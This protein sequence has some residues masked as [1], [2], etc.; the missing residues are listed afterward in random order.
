MFT[1]TQEQLDSLEYLSTQL[2]KTTGTVVSTINGQ[3]LTPADAGQTIR[4]ILNNFNLPV[5]VQPGQVLSGGQSS[6]VPANF[7]G[8][9]VGEVAVDPTKSK[10]L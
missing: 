9:K 8:N 6:Y 7:S 4:T 3:T 5:Q 1:I 10:Y 2:M